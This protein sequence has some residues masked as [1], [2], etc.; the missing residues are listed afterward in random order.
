MRREPPINGTVGVRYE[1]TGSSYWGE[2]F[3]RGAVA[4]RRLSRGDIRDPRIPGFTR[5]VDDVAFDTDGNA[6]DAGTPGFVT[7]NARAGM[8]LYG[9]G[10]VTA[11][12]ENIF[13]RRYRW[14]GSG[15]DAP[16]RN[17]VLSLENR[18]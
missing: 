1:P 18:F 9:S 8:S 10:R 6:V 11:A 3:A 12:V 15:V 17:L 2:F 13:D 7:V 16:G 5:N 14:H 4:Q